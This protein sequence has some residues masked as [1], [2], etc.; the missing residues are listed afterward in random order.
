MTRRTIASYG[1][2]GRTVRV[3]VEGDLV[4]AQWRERGLLKTKSWANT[5]E[6]RRDAKAWAH[7]FADARDAHPSRA[8]RLTLRE[9]WDAYQLAEFPH[10]RPN[11][12]RLYKDGWQ[13]WEQPWGANFPAADASPQMLDE[14][15]RT[16]D[17]SGLA[18]NTAR[19]TI[20]VVKAVYAFG[21]RRELLERN[22]LA[23]WRFKLAK[24]KRP[25]PPK[26]FT[27]A[28]FAKLLGVLDPAKPSQWRAYVA[29]ALCGYQGVRQN[30]VLHLRWDDV[31]F[32]GGVIHWR[33][34]WDKVGKDWS[35]PMREGSRKA[36]EAAQ[37]HATGSP[38]VFPAPKDQTRPYTIQS[39][40]WMLGYASRT[41]GVE[42]IKGR[43]AHGL[44]RMLAGDVSKLTGNVTLALQAIGD[45]SLQMASRYIQK[46]DDQ[47]AD[48]FERLDKQEEGNR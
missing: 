23:S 17:K 14:F 37:R 38:W 28:E 42:R 22:R 16:L 1:P 18:V 9:L 24:E 15:R 40:W 43:G 8:H 46:R 10:L 44:R 6:N 30:A 31:D 25:E 33:A 11:T 19:L 7:G 29:L 47:V 4:R 36:L 5:P 32:V 35:Q 45:T 12:I 3:F 21:E 27:G 41:A 2:K 13:K 48:A 34:A 20:R 39:L 26:E